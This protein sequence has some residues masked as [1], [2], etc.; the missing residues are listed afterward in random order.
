MHKCVEF[1]VALTED[2]RLYTVCVSCNRMPKNGL[3]AGGQISQ[4]QAD[5]LRNGEYDN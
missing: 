4:E 5:K 3:F 1:G 2:N